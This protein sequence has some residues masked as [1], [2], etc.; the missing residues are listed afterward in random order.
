MQGWLGQR[1]HEDQVI[2]TSS[3]T[4]VGDA[5]S[6]RHQIEEAQKKRHKEMEEI[7]TA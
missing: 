1:Q 3:K 4:L 5:K 7:G 6:P 2:K